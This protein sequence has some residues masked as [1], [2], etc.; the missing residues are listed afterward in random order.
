MWQAEYV[1]ER[2]KAGGMAS[3]II[4]IDT[5]GDK[6]LDVSIN[7]IGSKGVF[8][9]E[10]EEQLQL[11]NIDIAVHS[12]KDMQSELPAG[13]EL[14]AF[15]EREVV[16]DV[17]VG[18]DLTLDLDKANITIGTASTRRVALLKHFY[19]HVKTVPIR[20]NLQ[21]RIAKMKDGACDALLLAY[22]GVHRMEYDDMIISKLPLDKFIPAV[23][24]GS[25][26]IE[27]SENLS[28]EK[29]EI[30][31]T[32]VNHTATEKRLRCERAFLKK[33]QGG[34]SIPV[35]ALADLQNDTLTIKGG[36]INL[37]GNKIIRKRIMGPAE[38]AEAI[39]YELAEEV[40]NA[41]GD[42]ILT[43]IKEKLN[44]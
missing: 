31:R 24:Q 18:Q 34:C 35:F 9:E 37:E 1:A 23:G 16:N 6:I 43:D 32:H 10:I 42:E 13:F 21:T 38:N 4:T 20:G 40:F 5:T 41:G 36:I 30:I 28:E 39:G 22:A 2:L 25:I 26:A 44:Q 33:L 27:C 19:P 14:L 12:A 8:T 17:L 11:N 3:E 29:R 15:T 7:K